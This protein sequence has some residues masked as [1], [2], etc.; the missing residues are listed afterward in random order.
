MT[1]LERCINYLRFGNAGDYVET[2]KC[3]VT[4][5]DKFKNT[6]PTCYIT[7]N[8][9]TREADAFYGDTVEDLK[10]MIAEE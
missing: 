6:L 10:R 4:R 5:K 9:K 2:S 8:G 1:E 7:E 3:K